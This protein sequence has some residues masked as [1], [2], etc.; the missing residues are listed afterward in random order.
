MKARPE[1]QNNQNLGISFNTN[2]GVELLGTSSV[3]LKRNSKGGTEFVIK[4]YDKDPGKAS[5]IA[6]TIYKSLNKQYPY[7]EEK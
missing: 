7:P 3:E 6:S 1:S 4:V 2:L 5:S